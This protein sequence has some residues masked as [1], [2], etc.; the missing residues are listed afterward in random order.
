MSCISHTVLLQVYFKVQ[1]CSQSHFMAISDAIYFHT[2]T[3]HDTERKMKNQ[4]Y[5]FFFIPSFKLYSYGLPITIIFKHL[6]AWNIYTLKFVL[7]FDWLCILKCSLHYIYTFMSAHRHNGLCRYQ[8]IFFTC[9]YVTHQLW[10]SPLVRWEMRSTQLFLQSLSSSMHWALLPMA[11]MINV[12][13]LNWKPFFLYS[14]PG[15]TK[16]SR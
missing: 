1:C 16:P 5:V 8:N 9:I 3:K 15:I 4:R 10:P 2:T 12:I 6:S 13:H 11:H 14:C 7:A